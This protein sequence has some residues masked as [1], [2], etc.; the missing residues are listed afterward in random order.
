MMLLLRRQRP[1]EQHLPAGGRGVRVVPD[2]VGVSAVV[3]VDGSRGGRQEKPGAG[4]GGGGLTIGVMNSMYVH[5]ADR[6]IDDASAP[7]LGSGRR[8]V[9]LP[10][11]LTSALTRCMLMV[12]CLCCLVTIDSIWLL[13]NLRAYYMD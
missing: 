12:C 10:V 4:G 8:L 6:S 9:L 13:V 7:P 1:V 3:V 5:Y 2:G 11:D